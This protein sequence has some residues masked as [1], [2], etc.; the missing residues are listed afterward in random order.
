MQDTAEDVAANPEPF[1]LL[2]MDGSR[3]PAFTTYQ[4]AVQYLAGMQGVKREEWGHWG[5]IRLDQGTHATTVLF[6]RLPAPQEVQIPAEA[7]TAVLVDMWGS[8]QTISASDG[9]FTV[10]LPGAICAQTAGDFCMIGGPVYYL[11]QSLDGGSVAAP[12]PVSGPPA[13]DDPP[14][15][16][17]TIDPDAPTNTPA[18]TVAPTETATPEPSSTPR[19]TVT[20][21]PTRTQTAT[22]TATASPT[23]TPSPTATISPTAVPATEVASLPPTPVPNQEAVVDTAESGSN[24]TP[25]LLGAAGLLL[26]GIAGWWW[27]GRGQS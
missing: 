24:R 4:V 26:L 17:A 16:T 11:V 12:P 15:A 5:Q 19:D 3:R 14:A 9:L 27:N 20:P 21:R 22:M 18:P 2:R 23:D 10:E 6:S 13:V 25:L 7:A 8:R 1:G